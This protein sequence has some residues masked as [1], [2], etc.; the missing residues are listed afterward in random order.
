MQA[1][2]GLPHGC[3]VV[4]GRVVFRNVQAKGALRQ[5]S[6]AGRERLVRSVDR[7][8]EDGLNK[9][10][11]LPTPVATY[12]CHPTQPNTPRSPRTLI[13]CTTH[14]TR[15]IC[16]RLRPR[17][18]HGTTFVKVPLASGCF[19]SH[20][21]HSEF[22]RSRGR[23]AR[24]MRGG[25]GAFGIGFGRCVRPIR[26]P[27]PCPNTKASTTSREARHQARVRR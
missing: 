3:L 5:G 10:S 17:S 14:C 4:P 21:K 7:V 19:L 1:G 20:H 9:E 12:A 26:I 22:G 18:L 11:G 24:V 25:I 2:R 16:G 23:L 6:K 27:A 8:V 15:W 13:S